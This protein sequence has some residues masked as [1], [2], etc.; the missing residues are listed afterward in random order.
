MV[1]LRF[2]GHAEA[3]GVYQQL[4]SF[5]FPHLSGVNPSSLMLG[6][7]GWLYGTTPPGGDL[8]GG[9]IFKVKKDG[10]GHTVVHA[11][12]TL[13]G[14]SDYPAGPLAQAPDGTLYGVATSGGERRRGAVFKL[15]SDGTGYETLHAFYLTTEDF[16]LPVGLILASDGILYGT[17]RS[18]GSH[19][20]GGVFRL[21][22]DGTDYRML[23][24]FTSTADHSTIV[25]ASD[26]LLYG[27]ALDRLFRIGKSGNG[28]TLLH[29]FSGERDG[30]RAPLTEGPDGMM[31]GTTSSGG[32]FG[33][34]AVFKIGKD[35]SNYQ[36]L[37]SFNPVGDGVNPWAPVVEGRDGYL[38]GT[39]S[40]GG[41]GFGQRGTIYRMGTDGTGYGVLRTFGGSDGD[42]AQLYTGLVRGGD[43]VLYGIT[44]GGGDRGTGTLFSFAEDGFAYRVVHS[45][46]LS[47]SDGESP[48]AGLVEARDG[49]LYGVCYQGGRFGAGSIFRIGKDGSGYALLDDF[50]RRSG[51]GFRPEQ[52]M[53][54]GSDGLLYGVTTGGGTNNAGTVFSFAMDS[55]NHVVLHS[56]QQN[57]TEAPSG[58]LLEGVDGSLYGTTSY[59]G[60]FGHGSIFKLNKDG[61]GYVLLHSFDGTNGRSPLAGVIQGRDGFLYGTTVIDGGIIFKV[62]TNGTGFAVLH[63]FAG[64]DD[65]G[66]TPAGSVME[67]SN[68]KLYGATQDGRVFTLNADGSEY[69]II[70]RL[71]VDDGYSPY[72]TLIEA[73][74]G[75]IYGTTSRGP[76]SFLG[77]LF[78]MNKDGSGFAV[79]HRFG[80]VPGDGTNPLSF[81]VEGSDGAIYGTTGWGGEMDFGT[82][83]RFGPAPLLSITLTMSGP[84][85]RF[86]GTGGRA[87]AIQ[88]ATHI[89]GNWETVAVRTTVPYDATEYTDTGAPASGAFYRLERVQ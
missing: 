32:E 81:L 21:N 50:S 24:P 43:G 12:E 33:S 67:A 51:D 30:C 72:G 44:Y 40:E 64:G 18:G 49:A 41:V 2:C 88:R 46:S 20:A 59:G 62:N 53:I 15:N 73:T 52:S 86:S 47:G 56:M 10:T 85:L 74:D 6:R 38:Y 35:G 4:K 79:L 57:Q 23:L 75:M 76:W 14:Q 1:L 37:H 71:G 84:R 34:G 65:D 42:G 17:A 39:T 19:G 3:Q 70:Y 48:W 16:D 80:S 66:Y 7:D 27:T 63:A 54:E 60:V 69:R 89:N 8:K 11:F 9:T 31:Y 61:S 26:G 82:V 29:T 5:G 25:E 13:L 87:Y 77:T 68:G 83:Y 45:F 78:R 36:V 55:T 58:R 28:Y 22:T